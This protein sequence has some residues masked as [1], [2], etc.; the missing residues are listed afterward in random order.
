MPLIL[1]GFA[2]DNISGPVSMYILTPKSTVNKY[3]YPNLPVYMLFGDIHRSNKNTCKKGTYNNIYDINFLI[4]LSTLAQYNEKI[5]FYFEG[6]DLHN[7]TFDKELQGNYPLNKIQQIASLC[8]KNEENPNKKHKLLF[9]QKTIDCSRIQKIR[10]QSGDLRH[11]ND[12]KFVKSLDTC[13]IYSFFQ[14]LDCDS[15]F[16]EDNE[17]DDELLE[18]FIDKFKTIFKHFNRR[19]IYTGCITKLLNTT[20]EFT[21]IQ[22]Q[23]LSESGLVMHQLR[24]MDPEEKK[25]IYDY[26]IKYCKE[27]KR[28]NDSLI[29]I[30]IQRFH[31]EI[32]NILQNLDKD[33]NSFNTESYTLIEPDIKFIDYLSQNIDTLRRYNNL[34]VL[35]YSIFADVY[36]LCRTFKYFNV[37]K[38]KPI[39]NIFYFGNYHIKNMVYFLETITQLYDCKTILEHKK[40]QTN[41]C[42]KIEDNIDLNTILRQGQTPYEPAKMLFNKSKS[43]TSQPSPKLQSDKCKCIVKTTR[44]PCE[45]KAKPGLEFCG[46]HKNYKK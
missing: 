27:V 10:W 3:I 16:K 24:H 1:N 46:V 6:G 7:R 29:D 30:S 34:L 39:L 35:N 20:L 12:D 33:I 41:R 13:T 31:L 5:D 2:V 44:K 26:I 23:L 15:F 8:Y 37:K 45:N 32:I 11:F 21:D 25:K 4:L 36:T 14:E 19:Y 43:R 42:I 40:G 9:E 17:A 22:T 38:D 18:M 28:K